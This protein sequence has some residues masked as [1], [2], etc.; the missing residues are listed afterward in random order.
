[1][2]ILR[3]A[4]LSTMFEK[5]SGKLS[6]QLNA[7]FVAIWKKAVKILTFTLL[8][9]TKCIRAC[10]LE[11]CF[12]VVRLRIVCLPGVSV[13]VVMVLIS[14]T[15]VVVLTLVTVIFGLLIT[16]VRLT[17]VRDPSRF[18]VTESFSSSAM[19]LI[20]AYGSSSHVGPSSIMPWC[21][22]YL[23]NATSEI[24]TAKKAQ[25]PKKMILRMIEPMTRSIKDLADSA[26]HATHSLVSGFR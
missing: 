16:T 24:C 7:M 12:R 8:V 2:S 4:K 22:L 15:G 10:H 21:S 3:I 20:D 9:W 1:M 25:A 18:S 13:A 5:L 6:A 11:L 26:W 14:L 23:A 19:R 17:N